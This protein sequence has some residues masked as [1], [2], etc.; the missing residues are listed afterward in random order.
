MKKSEVKDLDKA[1][2]VIHAGGHPDPETGAIMPP[3]YQTSTYVQSSPGVHKG[4]EYTRSHNPTRTRLEE[5]LASLEEAKYA[6]VT[7]SGL[8]AEMLVM[9]TLP[10]G[11]TILCGDDVYGGTYR[12]FTTVFNEIHNFI[13]INTTDLE[14]VESKIKEHRP[15]LL[16][17]ETPTNPLLKITDIMKVTSIAKK[18]KV[19]TLVD[20]T[21]MSPYFQNPLSLGAD[22]VLHSMTKY[23]NGHSDVVGG[24][25]MLNEKK[26]YDKLWTLQNSIGP[27]QSPF[28]SWLVLRG[29]KTLAIRMEAHQKNA[30]KIAKFLESHPMVE[31]VLYPGLKSHPQ[32]RIAKIQMSGFGGMITFFLKGDIKKSKK[33]LSK[34]QIFSLAES[35]GGVESLIEHPAIMTHASIPKKTRETLGITDNLIRLSVGIENVDD[36]IRDLENTFKIIR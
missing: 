22:I 32:H 16:W 1:S 5:C 30:M 21:F 8:S 27:S 4:Y 36:L 14:E 20:N 26:V 33:F 11:S 6:L 15:S 13:F 24:A 7:S 34:I 17:I 12:L 31:K 9:H 10:A 29:I 25:L 35:L 2:R 28:D 18:Y 19:K 23:I 3:I